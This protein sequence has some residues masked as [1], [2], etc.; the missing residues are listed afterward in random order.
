MYIIGVLLMCAASFVVGPLAIVNSFENGRIALGVTHIIIVLLFMMV[1]IIISMIITLKMQRKCN[2]L[3]LDYR[4]GDSSAVRGLKS[5][6]G[7]AFAFA[8]ML[9]LMMCFCSL[10]GII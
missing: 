2:N 9:T 10:G 7:Y 3:D 4:E 8:V 5:A 6:G 1:A